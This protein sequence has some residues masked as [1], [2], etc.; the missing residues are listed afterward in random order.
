MGDQCN[1]EL[2]VS[3]V[4]CGGDVHKKHELKDD[5]LD[6]K[7]LEKVSGGKRGVPDDSI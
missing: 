3:K 6:D 7:E 5:E 2:D 1:K 4:V